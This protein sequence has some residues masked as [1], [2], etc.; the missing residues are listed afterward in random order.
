MKTL[1]N[2][3]KNFRKFDFEENFENSEEI[4]TMCY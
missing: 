2:F 4:I 3:E 1:E